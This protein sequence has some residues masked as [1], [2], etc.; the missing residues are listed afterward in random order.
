MTALREQAMPVADRPRPR[1]AVLMVGW[2]TACASTES[3][4]PGASTDPTLPAQLI[5]AT[6]HGLMARWHLAAHSVSW[7]EVAE[8]LAEGRQS[9]GEGATPHDTAVL[10]ATRRTDEPPVGTATQPRPRGREGRAT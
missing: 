10:Y 9:P 4:C 5:T 8:A 7:Q 3:E 1:A 2:T 6:L